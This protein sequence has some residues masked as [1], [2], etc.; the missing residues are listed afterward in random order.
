MNKLTIDTLP[1]DVKNNLPE[2]ARHFFMAAYNS[3]LDNGQSEETAS[4]V[5]W[6]TI[7]NNEHYAQSED[8]KW[9]RLPDESGKHASINL[10]AS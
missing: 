9:H 8:G 5:A 4:R 1:E 10:T 6:Q 2:E 3:I 7:A